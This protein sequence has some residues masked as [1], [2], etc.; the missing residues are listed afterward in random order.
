MLEMRGHFPST[1]LFEMRSSEPEGHVLRSYREGAAD[2]LTMSM[3][4]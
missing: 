1:E 4:V 3:L 2:A